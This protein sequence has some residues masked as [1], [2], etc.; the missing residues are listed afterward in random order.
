MK[1]PSIYKSYILR[2]WKVVHNG[3]PVWQASIQSTAT[4]ERQ[5]FSDMESLITHLT[6]ADQRPEPADRFVSPTPDS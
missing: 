6:E 4:G 5:G 2:M 3:Q 1:S